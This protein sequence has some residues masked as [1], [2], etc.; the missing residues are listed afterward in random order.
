V[1]CYDQFGNK[2]HYPAGTELI[3]VGEY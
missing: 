2:I 3:V 1:E